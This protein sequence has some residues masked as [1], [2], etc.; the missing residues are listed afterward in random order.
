MSE[1]HSVVL[2]AVVQ[3][4]LEA[5]PPHELDAAWAH[6][7]S[8]LTLP[9]VQPATAHGGQLVAL[10]TLNILALSLSPACPSCTL[11]LP[12]VCSVAAAASVQAHWP[13]SNS[14]CS[15]TPTDHATAAIGWQG[16]AVCSAAS[17]AAGCCG[18]SGCL[19]GSTAVVAR[20]TTR[21]ASPLDGWRCLI[22]QPR[23]QVV[24]MLDC[25]LVGTAW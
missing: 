12:G 3:H 23:P 19:A 13:H 11:L 22:F 20:S 4:H 2:G 17:A 1:S 8:P 10:S 14:R 5:D 7:H 18:Q 24:C 15:C 9:S 6:T 16:S 21:W 25:E